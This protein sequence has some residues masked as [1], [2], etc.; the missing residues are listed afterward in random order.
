MKKL[1]VSVFTLAT[2]GFATSGV[3]AQQ[4]QQPQEQSQQH[5]RS[6]KD[7]NM[8]KTEVSETEL[9]NEVREGWANSHYQNSK[10]EKI[11]KI[12]GSDSATGSAIG[13]DSK[14]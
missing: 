2:L 12:K 11:Y 9:P 10:V 5:E 4:K 8:D 1:I 7:K 13:T 3:F 6:Q 14:E